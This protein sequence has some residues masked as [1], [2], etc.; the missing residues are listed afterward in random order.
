MI[1]T[2][3]IS[4]GNLVWAVDSS[5]L[6]TML[7]PIEVIFDSL[8]SDNSTKLA[9]IV[10]NSKKLCFPTNMLFDNKDE[11]TLCASIMYY[12]SY[13]SAYEDDKTPSEE[14]N[15]RLLDYASTQIEKYRVSHPDKFLYYW[16]NDVT[17]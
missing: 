7:Y 4:K 12:K 9:F 1:D 6:D 2:N 10:M 3:N 17:G 13:E 15:P 14:Y 5:K 11:A 16:M 8:E